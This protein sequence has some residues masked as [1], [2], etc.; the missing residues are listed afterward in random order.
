MHRYHHLLLAT[1]DQSR[2]IDQNTINSLGI[3]GETLMEIA[4]NRAADIISA[5]FSP[6]SS[7]LF[8]LG[9]GNNAGDALVIAR[10]LLNSGYRV[11]LYPVM[12]TD[13]FSPDAERNFNR[14]MYLSRAMDIAIPIWESWQDHSGHD[15]VVDGI[16]G[17]G[18]QSAVRP[19]VSEIINI[20]N[21]SEKPVY[22]LDIP[23]GLLCDSGEMPGA[24]IR[25]DKTI[26]F[27]IRKRGCY[28]GD[29]PACSGN[30]E[31]VPLPFPDIY[32]QE[33]TMR[34]V[35]ESRDPVSFLKPLSPGKNTSTGNVPGKVLHK[36]DNGVVHVIGGSAG[37]TGAP[38]Y[39]AQS[40]WSL[41]MGAVSLIHPYAWLPAMDVQAPELI[42]KP[43]GTS[44]S[45]YF[46]ETDAE[47]VLSYINDKKGVTVIGPG[48]GT[49]PDTLAFVRKVVKGSDGP[50]I[51]DA[52]GLRCLYGFE[53]TITQRS[54]PEQVILTPHPG[55]LSHITKKKPVNDMDRLKSSI[56]L[57]ERLGCVLLSK[58]HPVFIHSP[59]QHET[60]FTGYDTSVFSRAGF[61][62]ILAG[63][64]AAFFART[65]NPL[66]SCENGLLYGFKKITEVICRGTLF[67]EP[68][69]LT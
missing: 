8:V 60:L 67:P 54:C 23:S 31:W 27:G 14:L 42:K 52:D 39:T 24:V 51:I 20:I 12:G 55:E 69:D 50:L 1:S 45:E 58:G 53:E 66:S 15:L 6:N 35:D 30:R 19:P 41:G 7:I 10:I 47:T 28:L 44:G 25:A 33:I 62:D 43:V 18:L 3:P 4:G 37:L 57:S 48:I 68:S 36:Y 22:A 56:E 13:Q 40:A 49:H 63:H 29:G 59:V 38:M 17:T 21:T 64:I 34:L 16:F 5:D 32:K 61:G 2:K 65:G 46:R 26:Q 11:T 9:K